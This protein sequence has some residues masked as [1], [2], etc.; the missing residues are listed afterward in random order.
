VRAE[1]NSHQYSQDSFGRSDFQHSVARIHHLL[2]DQ[3][4]TAQ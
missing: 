1:L 2:F 3:A 4:E